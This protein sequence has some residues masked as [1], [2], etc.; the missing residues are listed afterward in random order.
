MKVSSPCPGLTRVE[1]LLD[2][3]ATL[4][5]K[6]IAEEVSLGVLGEIPFDGTLLKPSAPDRH[7]PV[8]CSRA[9]KP[10]R[11]SGSARRRPATPA[12]AWSPRSMHVVV[13]KRRRALLGVEPFDLGLHRGGVGPRDL[14][15][16]DGPHDT[17]RSISTSACGPV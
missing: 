7:P 6:T 8:P 11:T 17:R 15:P 3:G 2:A 10:R 1:R 14:V 9:R 16:P 12:R 13:R 5:G 4:I